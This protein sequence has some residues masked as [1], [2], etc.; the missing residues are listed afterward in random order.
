[1]AWQTQ[2]I[3][4][5][6]SKG[7][8]RFTLTVTEDNT[9]INTNQSYISWSFVLSPIVNGWDWYYSNQVPVTWIYTIN[10]VQYSG[11]IMNYDG[12]STVTI[13]SGGTYITHESNGYKDIHFSFSVS[14]LNE[15]YLPGYASASGS[16]SLTYIPRQAT[17][18]SAP[19][20][21]DEE[22]PTIIY[23]N[24][25]G[26]AVDSL[27]AC[28]IYYS[29]DEH[30]IAEYRAIPKTGTSYTF[31]FTDSEKSILYE[32]TKNMSTPLLVRFY[33]TTVIGEN[34]Y[35]STLDRAVTIVN[36]CPTISE[37]TVVDE[38]SI[39]TAITNNPNVVINGCN[40]M[41]CT[42]SAT[43]NK[44]ST[45]VSKKVTCGS[46]SRE[47]LDDYAVFENVDSGTFIFTVVDSRGNVTSVT[48]TKEFIPYYKPTCNIDVDMSVIED[49]KAKATIT[50]NGTLYIYNFG[51][52]DH[53]GNIGSVYYRY[54]NK[55]GEYCDWIHIEDV[56]T[57]PNYSFEIIVSDLDYK[58]L[59][60]FQAKIGDRIYYGNNAVLS[61]EY[62]ART[63]PVFDWGENDFNFNVPIKMY[64]KE[65]H[66]V[67]EQGEANGWTYRKWS[68]GE[69]ECW[70][71][72]EHNTA[73]TNPWGSM[74]YGTNVE[75]QSYPFQFSNKPFEQ[76][77]V[78]CGGSSAW[79]CC[80]TNGVNDGLASA[81]YCI[82]SP[83]EI[84]S[85][86]TFYLN[87]YIKGI[88]E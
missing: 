27:K 82:V 9:N 11:N 60:S 38:G 87:Y 28:I 20:F 52:S 24:P 55:N 39:S 81:I 35:W 16:M 67:I 15:T 73:L 49:T 69:A 77:T 86:Q 72:V 7:H 61:V 48:V 4:G 8:H 64:G 36:A 22:N 21:T 23:S 83:A 44:G 70:K 76:V 14:S 74:Y 66:Y 34:T 10:G 19:N 40:Y 37:A 88:Y 45:I 59:Y 32:A 3:V 80:N 50:I 5:D 29:P 42:L 58:S 54:K 53:D 31:N 41:K 46:Q 85:S 71:V 65:M 2:Y 26:E 6:G 18:T 13:S 33:V 68:N 75:R 63:V 43:A 17:I 12:S 47:I 78:L 57:N 56:T 51:S 79:V 1:M 84:S 25:A 62:A 30:Y